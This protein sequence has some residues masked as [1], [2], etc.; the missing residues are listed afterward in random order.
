MKEAIGPYLVIEKIKGGPQ[1]VGG[2]EIAEDKNAELRF[3][4]AKVVS[5]GG[6]AKEHSKGVLKP[7]DIIHYDKHAAHG[8]DVEDKDYHVI[9][10]I[11]VAAID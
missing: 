7:G 3:V 4:K 5:V 6:L 9:K 8:I 2:I 1:M 11:D 10:L